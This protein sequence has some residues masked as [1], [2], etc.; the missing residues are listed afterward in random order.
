MPTVATLSLFTSPLR[1]RLDE[2]LR[3]KGGGNL[4]EVTAWLEASGI[5]ADKASVSTYA[6]RLKRAHEFDLGETLG[7]NDIGVVKLR[8]QCVEIA[9]AAGGDDLFSLADQVLAWAVEPVR[10]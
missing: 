7:L 2:K 5:N 8:L 4:E 3:A 1:G 6:Q 10:V 9:A